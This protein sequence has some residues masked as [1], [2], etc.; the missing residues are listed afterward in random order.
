MTTPHTYGTKALVAVS[1]VLHFLVDGLCVCCLYQVVRPAV[2]VDIVPVFL[3]YNILAFLSQPLTGWVA[4]VLHNRHWLLVASVSLLSLAVFL[5]G[6]QEFWSSGVQ[7]CGRSGVQECGSAGVQEVGSSGVVGL[8]VVAALLGVGNSLFHVWGGKVVAVATGNDIRA[9]GVFV[10][11]G[12]FGLTVGMVFASWWLLFV[13]LLSIALLVG[14]QEYRSVG[15]Q[16]CR[17]SCVPAVASDQR[18]SAEVQECR[19]AGVCVGIIVAL[20]AFVML[21]SLVGETFS[22]GVLESWSSGVLLLVGFVA[23]LGKMAGGWIARGMGSVRAFVFLIVIV[24]GCYL[25]VQEFGSSGVQEFGS[26]GV[27]FLAG[28]LLVNCTMPITLYWA[29]VVMRGREG[30]AFGLLAAALMPGYVLANI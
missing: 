18:S 7:E 22:S 15:V 19:S 12:A 25:G 3:T 27:W 29:N 13:M 8:F 23:M 1:A 10:S 2:W 16:E 4:D 17:S 20:M 26:P 24:A 11:T 21:R 6:V 14:V 28:L 30:L 5:S 9:L